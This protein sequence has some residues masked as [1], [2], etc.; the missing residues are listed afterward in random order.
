MRANNTS[1]WSLLRNWEGAF[2]SWIFIVYGRICGN[3]LLWLLRKKSSIHCP[4]GINNVNMILGTKE[5]VLFTNASTAENCAKTVQR[6]TFYGWR[7]PG[8]WWWKLPQV[9]WPKLFGVSLRI[10]LEKLL[11]GSTFGRKLDFQLFLR[12]KRNKN[13]EIMPVGH[14]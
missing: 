8:N 4:E 1:T 7:G 12:E 10:Y 5:S 13:A 3:V 2:M 11:W 9:K 14:T 6:S